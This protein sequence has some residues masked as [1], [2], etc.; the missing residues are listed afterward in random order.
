MK[1]IDAKKY[2][3]KSV[4]ILGIEI[5]PHLAVPVNCTAT[6][7]VYVVPS[8]LEEGGHVLEAKFERVGLPVI[9][10]IAEFDG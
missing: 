6:I 4:N 7:N 5:I 9:C 10:I 2:W 8:K 3:T 1:A